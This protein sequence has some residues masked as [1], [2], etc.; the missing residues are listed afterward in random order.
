MGGG[1][2]GVFC[3]PCWQPCSQG[4]SWLTPGGGKLRDPGNKVALLAFLPSVIFSFLPK[5]RGPSP[6]SITGKVSGKA[7]VCI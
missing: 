6:R 4:L 5:I 7:Q 3:L 2:G 1:G